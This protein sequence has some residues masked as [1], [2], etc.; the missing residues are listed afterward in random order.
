MNMFLCTFSNTVY[1][2]QREN[3]YIPLEEC[4]MVIGKT[5]KE[6]MVKWNGLPGMSM[7]ESFREGKKDIYTLVVV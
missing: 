6:S 7:R 2:C 3:L 1:F 5:T 4:M